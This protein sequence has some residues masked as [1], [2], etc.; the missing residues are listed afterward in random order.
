MKYRRRSQDCCGNNQ[1]DVHMLPKLTTRVTRSCWFRWWT[2][3]TTWSNNNSHSFSRNVWWCG[4]VGVFRVGVY[5]S[6][7]RYWHGGVQASHKAPQNAAPHPDTYVAT[8]CC[9]PLLLHVKKK[10][11]SVPWKPPSL[12]EESV[13]SSSSQGSLEEAGGHRQL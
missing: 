11:R 1:R 6:H 2:H 9:D 4:G 8:G 12:Q 3:N 10:I 7:P 5:R 13:P